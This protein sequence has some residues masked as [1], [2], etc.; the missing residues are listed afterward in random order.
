[1]TTTLDEAT[2]QIAVERAASHPDRRTRLA[3]INS[4][5]VVVVQRGRKRRFRGA[6]AGT[7]DLVGYVLGSGVH[8]EVELKRAGGRSRPAQRRRRE[9]AARDGWIYVLIVADA[10]LTLEANVRRA[11]ALIDVAILQHE[12]RQTTRDAT[13]ETTVLEHELLG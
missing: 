9:A 8:L 1:M 2:F 10:S 12:R 7:G 13:R 4:G 6:P 11:V 5:D 3:R